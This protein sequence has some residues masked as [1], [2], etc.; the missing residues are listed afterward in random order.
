MIKPELFS[1]GMHGPSTMP[2]LMLL[3]NGFFT[4]RAYS[5]GLSTIK[6]FV[7]VKVPRIRDEVYPQEWYWARQTTKPS[8][9][10]AGKKVN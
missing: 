8:V 5:S 1:L 9:F 7:T 6:Y 4:A 2:N 10:Q 3:P